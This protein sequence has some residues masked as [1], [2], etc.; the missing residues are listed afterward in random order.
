MRR[1]RLNQTQMKIKIR[2][3]DELYSNW[4]MQTRSLTS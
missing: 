3:L 1:L 4:A 2:E